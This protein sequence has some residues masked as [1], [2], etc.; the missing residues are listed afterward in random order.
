MMVIRKS[1]LT[2]EGLIAIVN[3][4]ASLNLGLSG[5]LQIAFPNV[6]PVNRPL[7]EDQVIRDPQ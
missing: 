3:T 7:V 6:V 5:E 2:Q 1:H 4:R